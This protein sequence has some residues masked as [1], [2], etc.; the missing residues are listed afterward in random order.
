VGSLTRSSGLVRAGPVRVVPPNN[1]EVLQFYFERRTNRDTAWGRRGPL[2]GSIGKH[3]DAALPSGVCWPLTTA[4][5]AI[6]QKPIQ[7]LPG[8]CFVP[9]V[10]LGRLRGCP[11]GLARFDTSKRPMRFPAG[12]FQA[13]EMRRGPTVFF[14]ELTAGAGA[15]EHRELVGAGLGRAG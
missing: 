2:G 13:T 1:G 5:L 3:G 6:P 11:L 14:Q 9:P 15:R 7:R 8:G 10:P 12:P 4:S